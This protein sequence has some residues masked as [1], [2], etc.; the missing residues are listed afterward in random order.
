MW[1]LLLYSRLRIAGRGGVVAWA[2]PLSVLPGLAILSKKNGFLIPV[3]LLALEAT[4]FR[5]RNERR[6]RRLL[7]AHFGVVAVFG[8]CLALLLLLDPDRLLA[9]YGGRPFDLAERLLTQAR[10]V[11]MY[12]GQI[13]LPRLNAMPFLYDGLPHST[14]EGA[15][16]RRA[17]LQDQKRYYRQYDPGP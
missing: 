13:L 6:S 11:A 1:A 2:L 16:P 8:L 12:V 3:L 5:L 14:A 7:S 9:G 4:L 15:N 17:C 10:V